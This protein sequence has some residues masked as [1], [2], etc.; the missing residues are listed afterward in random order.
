MALNLTQLQNIWNLHQELDNLL[1]GFQFSQKDLKS[2]LNDLFEFLKRTIKISTFY[3][4]T[5]NEKLINTVY[6]FGK[7]NKNTKLK[8][9]KLKVV[10]EIVNIKE[11]DICWYALSIDVDSHIIGTVAIGYEEPDLIESEEFYNETI[12]TISELIDTFIYNIQSSSIKHSLIMG[13]QDALADIDISSSLDRTTKL[14][15]H[16]IKFKRMLIVY[17][18]KDIITVSKNIKYIKIY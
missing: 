3:V 7:C 2:S 10:N 17:T 6:T 15:H 5:K 8:H 4:E 12:I 14:L 9:P 13:L 1:E 16:S 11:S 18:D